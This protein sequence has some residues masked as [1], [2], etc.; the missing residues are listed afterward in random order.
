MP[1]TRTRIEASEAAFISLLV[2]TPFNERKRLRK[3][4]FPDDELLTRGA[5]KLVKEL[6][7][8]PEQR[9]VE[10][11]RAEVNQFLMRL[12]HHG[13]M[14]QRWRKVRGNYSSIVTTAAIPQ[15]PHTDNRSVDWQEFLKLLRAL[16]VF[17][18]YRGGKTHLRKLFPD[19]APLSDEAIATITALAN[20]RRS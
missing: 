15:A 7:E 13:T 3:K 5:R 1:H 16:G 8:V 6:C 17:Q 2:E 14:Y 4:H 10:R 20:P 18:K 12:L 11:V 19:I 9:V